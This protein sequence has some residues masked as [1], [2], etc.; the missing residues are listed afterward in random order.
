MSVAEL[1]QV[2]YAWSTVARVV[3]V[4]QNETDYQRLV[5]VLDTLIDTV[6]EDETHP[7]TSLMNVVELSYT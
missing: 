3:F 2:E 6:G 4:P 5:A 1:Q 7:L